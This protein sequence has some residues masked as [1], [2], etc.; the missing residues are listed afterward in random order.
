MLL[1]FRFASILVGL[2]SLATLA[3]CASAPARS[4]RQKNEDLYEGQPSAI[5]G[6]E[7]PAGSAAEAAARGDLAIRQGELDRA[8][9]FYVEAVHLDPADTLSF[10]KIGAIH[11]KR[12]SHPLALEAYRRVLA[13]EADSVIALEG[14]G[15]SLLELRRLEPARE[16]LSRAVDLDHTRWRSHE[17]LG[18]ISDL[19]HGPGW[20]QTS[21]THYERALAVHESSTVYNNLGYSSYMAGYYVAAR[22]A[23]DRAVELDPKFDR[24]WRNLALVLVKTERYDAALAAL[25][26]VADTA[27]AYHDIG[28]LAMLEGRYTLAE[29]YLIRAAEASPQYYRMAYE[30]LDRVEKLRNSVTVV[31]STD[32]SSST[33]DW[34][35]GAVPGHGD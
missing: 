33:A 10:L 13:L 20:Y 7:F 18:V 12:Q 11:R 8:L 17:G 16:M 32:P 21:R 34:R 23:F 15:L 30:N 3:G 35:D 2:V 29:E 4:D 25:Q 19:D 24:A 26:R 5:F 9:Y 6:T 27:E 22:D 28:Y 14:A 31:R 1:H